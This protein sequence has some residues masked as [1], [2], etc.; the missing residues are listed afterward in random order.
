ML[1]RFL[2]FRDYEDIDYTLT[3]LHIDCMNLFSF[4]NT[5]V[6]VALAKCT[7]TSLELLKKRANLGKYVNCKRVT[8]NFF[9]ICFFFLLSNVQA[10]GQDRNSIDPFITTSMELESSKCVIVPSI[11]KIQEK[12]AAVSIM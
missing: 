8:V 6:V 1:F 7:K 3:Q 2:V 9:L 5:E 12:F 10:I 11:E 4:F